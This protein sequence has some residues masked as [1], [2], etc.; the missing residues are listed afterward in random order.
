MVVYIYTITKTKKY[1]NTE[2]LVKIYFERYLFYF[3]FANRN[4]GI[5]KY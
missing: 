3:H 4:N 1:L 5:T 2:I